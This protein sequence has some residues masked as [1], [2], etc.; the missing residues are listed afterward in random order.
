M[1]TDVIIIGAGSSGLSAAKELTRLGL[2]F[3][4]VEGSHRIGGR[5][6][7]EEIAPGVWF[8][9]GCSYLHQGETNPFVAIADELGVVLGKDKSDLF[10]ESRIGLYKNGVPLNSAEREAYTAYLAE[11]F[12]AVIAAADRGEDVAIVDLVDL[13]NEFATI[14]M[15]NWADSWTRDLDEISS[16]DFANFVGGSDIPVLNGYGNLVASWGSDVMV[17]LNTKVERIDWSRDG[18]SAETSRG[19]LRGRTALC[20]VSTGI[21]AAGEI[22][23]VPGLPDWKMEAVV[24]LPTGTENK[25]C[26]HFDQDVFGPEGRG[27]YRIWN[28]DGAA[29]GFEAGVMGHNTAVAFSGGRFAVWLEKQGQQAGHDYAVDRVAEAFGND[30][31]KHVTRSIV[32]AWSTEPW[33][34]GSYS[35]ALPGQAHQRTELARALDDRLFFAGEATTVSDYGCC[36][37]AYRSGIRAAQEISQTLAS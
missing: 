33:T 5:A 8:D 36:H 37:G 10:D 25:I 31:R 19:T 11:C 7:S 13:E 9:L 35:C 24:G 3:T 22:D 23:F 14:L 6:Y 17:S 12:T 1:E 28:D 18:V 15:H 30:I 26:L 29:G 32:T 16:V 4:L 21:L 34:W 2:S 20:T 27:F